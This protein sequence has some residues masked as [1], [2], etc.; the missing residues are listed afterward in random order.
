MGICKSSSSQPKREGRDTPKI[1]NVKDDQ[2]AKGKG[3][4]DTNSNE[5][6]ESICFFEK[7]IFEVEQ[8]YHEISAIKRT[9]SISKS[10]KLK[11]LESVLFNLK[12]KYETLPESS[13]GKY[14]SKMREI[15]N[16]VTLLKF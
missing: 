15:S 3:D 5:R 10:A 11:E 12:Q 16:G 7:E 1:S 6:N 9:K 4:T 2:T 8:R 13:K 14:A